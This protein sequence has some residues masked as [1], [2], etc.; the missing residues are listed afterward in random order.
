M[1]FKITD[2]VSVSKPS[3]AIGGTELMRDALYEKVKPE[4]WNNLKLIISKITD[5]DDSKNKLLWLHDLAQDPQYGD[6]KNQ[7]DIFERF[8]FVSHWQQN[9]FQTYHNIP[10]NKSV[11]IRNAIEPIEIHEKP[12]DTKTKFIYTSTPHR[13]LG[14]L[15]KAVELLGETRDDF[16]VDVYSSFSIYGWD[17]KQVEAQDF[18]NKISEHKNINYHGTVSNAEVRKALKNSHIF[19]YPS[20]YQ[21]TY[22][23]SLVEAMSA[24]CMCLIPNLGALPEIG[25]SFPVMYHYEDNP[26]DHAVLFANIMNQAIDMYWDN[27]IQNKL[28]MQKHHTNANHS[29]D[30]RIVE[31]TVFLENLQEDMKGK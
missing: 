28:V 4:L 6:L 11:V 14:I 13:G 18:F 12:K 3:K 23:L 2:D 19:A 9:M 10:W 29:W 25:A 22:C 31:W 15:Y 8:I 30:S 17:Q 24:G 20:I 7:I 26:I 21:E 16:E 5:L 27:G 1:E